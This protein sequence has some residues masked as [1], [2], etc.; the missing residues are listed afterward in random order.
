MEPELA[1]KAVPSE[2]RA[3]F[4]NQRVVLRETSRAVMSFGGVAAFVASLQKLS[5]SFRR[6]RV[7]AGTD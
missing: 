3:L 5:V 1:D 2:V 6:G 7:I 4:S